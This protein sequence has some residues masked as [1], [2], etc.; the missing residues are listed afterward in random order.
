MTV[1]NVKIAQLFCVNACDQRT[2]A[3]MCLSSPQ[4]S[5]RCIYWLKPVIQPRQWLSRC[6][7][8]RAIGINH[9]AQA[10]Q[11]VFF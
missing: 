5:R 8:M 3:A 7:S 1:A 4:E 10:F 9:C 6:Q 2:Q 11:N